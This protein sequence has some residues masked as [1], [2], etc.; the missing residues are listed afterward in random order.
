MGGLVAHVQSDRVVKYALRSNPNAY[1]IMARG[2]ERYSHILPLS[3]D[4]LDAALLDGFSECVTARVR[5]NQ[6]ETRERRAT[7]PR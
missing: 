2:D 4:E 3:Y 6:T 7:R 1:F 5:L